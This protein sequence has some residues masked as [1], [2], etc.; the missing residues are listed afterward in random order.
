MI[1]LRKI[2]N[3]VAVVLGFVLA[4]GSMPAFANIVVSA[5]P[6]ITGPVAGVFT[7][8]Y[9]TSL[10]SGENLV[11]G[12]FFTL[13]DFSGL[14]AGTITPPSL[15]GPWTITTQNVG[16]TPATTPGSL[17]SGLDNSGLPNVTFTY[18]GDR[19]SVV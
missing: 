15:S 11:S 17:A 14:Q 18:T 3:G 7:W 19:K 1:R 2:G 10:G 16:I 9:G 13:Y 5:T 4:F 8:T 6:T 12:S